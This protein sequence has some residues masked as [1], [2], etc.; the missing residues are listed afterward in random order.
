MCTKIFRRLLHALG[1]SDLKYYGLEVYSFVFA[2]EK[3]PDPPL[4]TDFGVRL[5]KLALS[6]ATLTTVRN[7]EKRFFRCFVMWSNE[8]DRYDHDI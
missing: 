3:L 1:Y 8:Y 6:A 4:T 5:I 2:V 7:M